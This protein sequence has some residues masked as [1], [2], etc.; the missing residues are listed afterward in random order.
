[1]K[2]YISNLKNL[3]KLQSEVFAIKEIQK[4]KSQNGSQYFALVLSDKSGEI[5]AKVWEDKIGLNPELDDLLR[6]DIV[7]VS[8]LTQN[9][10][11][12]LQIVVSNIQ[13]TIDFDISDLVATSENNIDDMWKKL[14]VY[15]ENMKNQELREFLTS[16][17]NNEEIQIKYKN[18]T[19][20]EFVHHSFVG[21]LLEHTLEML[22]LA[23]PFQT[24]YRMADFD[25][26]NAGIILH[27]IG[28]VEEYERSGAS[29]VRTMRGRLV[30]H[31][32]EGIE[33][34][35]KYLPK[36]FPLDIW[37]QIQHIIISHH[38]KLEFGAAVTPC[39]I[40]AM[41]VSCVD[42]SSSQ[43]RQFR[44]IIEENENNSAEFSQYDKYIGAGVYLGNKKAEN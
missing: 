44:Q 33:I 4:H 17:L 38:G 18:S 15:I 9:Y 13:K 43:V 36:D 42:Y 31:I 12:N 2:N 5:K 39:T 23:Q 21:G 8:G 19:A 1:M 3:D 35:L 30:G 26:V 10:L 34:I 11:N 20:S 25:I 6:G 41:I 29:F 14:F 24:W 27:D 28:K 40:E 22:E 37:S 32:N 16:F 7:R